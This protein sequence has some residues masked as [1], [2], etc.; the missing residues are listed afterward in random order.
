MIRFIPFRG[1]VSTWQDIYHDLPLTLVLSLVL[2][3]FTPKFHIKDKGNK[4]S[5]DKQE[6]AKE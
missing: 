6:D 3:I 4:I 1:S 5:D 2:F